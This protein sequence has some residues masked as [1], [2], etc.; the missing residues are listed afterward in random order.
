MITEEEAK[1]V[2]LSERLVKSVHEARDTEYPDIEDLLSD[3]KP[4]TEALHASLML[5]IEEKEA[6]A[7]ELIAEANRY[8]RKCKTASEALISN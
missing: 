8:I 4:L 3:P 6:N 2:K 7:M 1:L 5:L